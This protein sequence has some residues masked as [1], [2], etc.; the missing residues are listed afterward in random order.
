MGDLYPLPQTKASPTQ[1]YLPV[2]ITFEA[3]PITHRPK[4]RS[5]TGT[6]HRNRIL[7]EH[8]FL[9]G[10]HD[11]EIE[12]FVEYYNHQRYHESLNNLTPSNIYFGHGQG[13]LM[14]RE[15]IQRRTIE[16]RRLMHQKSTV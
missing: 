9:P 13:I 15:G 7:L 5:S 14:I 10:G 2:W 6:R 4:A 12:A 1:Q 8:Y 11:A 3:H 16:Q